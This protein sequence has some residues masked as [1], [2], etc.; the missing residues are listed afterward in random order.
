LPDGAFVNVAREAGLDIPE[1]GAFAWL[2]IENDGD[3][4]L[5]WA[6]E[7]GFRVFVNQSGAFTPQTPD[8]PRIRGL[9]IALG[10]FDGDGDGDVFVA[11]PD[12]NLLYRND[13]G[14][15]VD[16]APAELGLPPKSL[17]ANWIDFD[18]DGRLDL[19]AIPGGLYRQS[20]DHHFAKASTPE[21]PSFADARAARAAWFDADNDGFRE[22]I[23]AVMQQ[24]K[25]WQV[26]YYR[27][28]G[29]RNHWLEVSLGGPPGNRPALGARVSITAAENQTAAVGWA[30]GSHYG[31]GHY[32]LYF[33]LGPEERVASLTVTWPDGSQTHLSDVA[34][35][36]LLELSWRQ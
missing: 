11:S 35:D 22:L 1:G 4:D 28:L 12:G 32:R 3:A 14:T 27:N 8:G 10:D 33:G 31:L 5:L 20:A 18:N 17:T 6:G 34:A 30:E 9:K 16:V 36:Q 15:L 21:L 24:D 29:N 2:D 25:Q 19:H 7:D 13:S 26:G 23:A